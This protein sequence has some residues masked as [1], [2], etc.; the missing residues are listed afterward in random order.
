L[1]IIWVLNNIKKDKSFY[2][3]LYILILIASLRLWKSFYKHDICTLYADELTLETFKTLDILYLWD[4]VELYTPSPNINHEIFW[5]AGKLEI[6]SQQNEPVI[7]VD[8]DLHIY[9][10]IKDYLE[11]DTAY[12]HN[13]EL[14][15]GYYPGYVDPYVRQL[16][17]KPRWKTDSLN[18]SFLHLPDVNFAKKYANKS[19]ELMEQFTQ[20][21]VPHSQ[22]LIFAEQ[23]LL[24]HLLDLDKIKY[25]SLVST[26]WDC[27]EWEWGEDHDQGI[28][29]LRESGL[30]VKHYGPLKGWIMQSKADQDYDREIKHLVNCINLPNLDLSSIEKL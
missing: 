10:P 30:Y 11:K 2:S 23:L 17:Y 15:K 6:L 26:Y 13:L 29:P 24:K 14:G 18:V 28:W 3:K 8:N 16:D 21:N 5:A 20:M 7:I 12:V 4:V 9:K 1:K 25:K 19:I 22:Y 27:T